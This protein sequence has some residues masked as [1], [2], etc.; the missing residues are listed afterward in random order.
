MWNS[1]KTATKNFFL[2]GNSKNKIFQKKWRIFNRLK[3]IL[4]KKKIKNGKLCE[5]KLLGRWICAFEGWRKYAKAAQ[6]NFWA[7]LGNLSIF[8]PRKCGK[9]FNMAKSQSIQIN[10]GLLIMNLKSVHENLLQFLR[11]IGFW[12]KSCMKNWFSGKTTANRHKRTSSLTSNG[13]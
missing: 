4:Y 1:W 2:V 3:R 9:I 11:K 10:L 6:S 5:K 13:I 8:E 7:P 12:A